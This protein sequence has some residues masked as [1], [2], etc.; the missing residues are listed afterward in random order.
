MAGD[1]NQFINNYCGLILE[2]TENN[3]INLKLYPNPATDYFCLSGETNNTELSIF[4]SIGQKVISEQ[5]YKD[6]VNIELLPAGLY[7]V[8]IM[9]N[10]ITLDMVKLIKE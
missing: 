4:N 8:R 5:W 9:K 3:D 10:N 1:N 7:F 6:E 2:V